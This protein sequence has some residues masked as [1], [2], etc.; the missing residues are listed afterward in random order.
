MTSEEQPIPCICGR[1]PE[2]NTIKG[3]HTYTFCCKCGDGEIHF[4]AKANNRQ[5]ALDGWTA[6]ITGKI[7]DRS[8]FSGLKQTGSAKE[9]VYTSIPTGLSSRYDRRQHFHCDPC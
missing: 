8:K 6:A 2:V 1:L 4:W 9:V 3:P 5:T 7:P